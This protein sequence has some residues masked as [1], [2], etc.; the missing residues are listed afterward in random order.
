MNYKK[1]TLFF[2]LLS[3][4][5]LLSTPVSAQ[6]NLPQGSQRATVTQRVGISDISIAYSRPS[7]NGREIWGKL[8]P[9]GMNNLGFGTA[10]E[11]PWRAGANEN[12]TISFTDQVSI[13]GKKVNAG[14]YGLF[15]EIHEDG[16]VDIILS[17]NSE[18]WGSYFYKREDDVIKVTVK[19]NKTTHTELL[20]FDFIAFDKTSTTAALKWGEKEIPFKIEVPVS[21]IVLEDIR[22]K[23][24][25][26][27]G[28]SNQNWIQAANYSLNNGG[29]LNEALSWVDASLSGNFFSQR[30]YNNLLAKSRILDKMG[31]TEESLKYV[32]EAASMANKNQL[33]NMGYQMLNQK[34]ND[35]AIKFFKMNVKNHPDDP[36]VYDSLG[37]GYKTIGDKKNAIKNLKKS[38]SMNPPANVKANSE[39]LLAEL[40]VK[41]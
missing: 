26:R 36:N 27:A 32:D 9:Y 40:G 41:I 31:K 34:Q 1:I 39:K 38:L 24:D 15:M 35:L 4:A 10:K 17:N 33:N 29:D 23:L 21:E 37:E 2:L 19:S 16:N 14:T 11:S 25:G 3:G 7:V 12:T 30:N 6:L 8:V 18:A 5:F 22:Q 13:E 28:F 20:T